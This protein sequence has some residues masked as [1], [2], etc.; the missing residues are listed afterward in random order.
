MRRSTCASRAS[1][2]PSPSRDHSYWPPSPFNKDPKS[3]WIPIPWEGAHE[4]H[5]ISSTDADSVLSRSVSPPFSLTSTGIS[6]EALCADV[7]KAIDK[8][9]PDRMCR[10]I[11][12]TNE[13]YA[14]ADP[15]ILPSIYSAR[16]ISFLFIE[17]MSFIEVI[18]SKQADYANQ[19]QRLSHVP[20]SDTYRRVA[21]L[22]CISTM[23]LVIMG[24]ILVKQ[25]QE[26][27]RERQRHLRQRV[28]SGK[29]RLA[30]L[31]EL[32]VRL[33]YHLP[34]Y[35]NHILHSAMDV[36]TSTSGFSQ[37]APPTPTPVPVQLQRRSTATRPGLR[38]VS[39]AEGGEV[40][41]SQ[42]CFRL[43]DWIRCAGDVHASVPRIVFQR[44]ALAV[45]M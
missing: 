36:F 20:I 4:T 11:H 38:L 18:E 19:L 12:M 40:R 5:S 15:K 26:T 6:A 14:Q 23:D 43:V 35:G 45:D 13:A 1:I 39:T 3:T 16:L 44:P 32:T 25:Q 2:L 7:A 21:D 22:Q 17:V 33:Q 9:H 41:R 28:A 8:G 27:T 37:K 30:T 29:A 31:H 34:Q 42:L 10:W 24:E